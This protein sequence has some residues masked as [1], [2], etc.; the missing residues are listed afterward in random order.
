MSRFLPQV[1]F[2]HDRMSCE[3]QIFGLA[4]STVFFW[5]AVAVLVVMRLYEIKIVLRLQ[6]GSGAARIYRN[7]RERFQNMQNMTLVRAARTLLA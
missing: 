2:S 6:K 3:L 4:P 1:A 5:V 7:A